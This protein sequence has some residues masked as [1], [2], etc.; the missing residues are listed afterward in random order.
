MDILFDHPE[1]AL[2]PCI[3]RTECATS[4]VVRHEI[5]SVA[6]EVLRDGLRERERKL[7]AR[8][9]LQECGADPES[10]DVGPFPSHHA[11]VKATYRAIKRF[12]G[13]L[14]AELSR[15]GLS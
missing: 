11:R 3:S 15:R 2:K 4:V 7:V 1:V 12:V 13:E 6:V 9:L 10:V 8:Y 14:T 5:Q